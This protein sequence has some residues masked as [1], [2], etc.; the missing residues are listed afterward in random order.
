MK[1]T[2]LKKSSFTL[3][4]SEIPVV[5]HLKKRLKLHSNTEVIRLALKELNAKMDRKALR[6]EFALA[7]RLVKKPNAQEWTETGDLAEEGL[8]ED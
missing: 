7:V 1:S 3:P 4:S 2:A 5:A 6:E 8:N